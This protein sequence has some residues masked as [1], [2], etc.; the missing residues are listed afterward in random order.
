MVQSLSGL[1]PHSASPCGSVP[2]EAHA[3]LGPATL[4]LSLGAEPAVRQ[5]AQ[6]PGLGLRGPRSAPSGSSAGPRQPGPCAQPPDPGSGGAALYSGRRTCPP[7]TGTPSAC[8]TRQAA[9]GAARGHAAA[10]GAERR[11]GPYLQPHPGRQGRVST[12]SLCP[13]AIKEMLPTPLRVTWG[14]FLQVADEVVPLV[15]HLHL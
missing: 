3:Q 6:R 13:E 5:E 8:A 10:R 4:G 2:T 15:S 9:G 11:G 7:T 12:C 1:P 14:S